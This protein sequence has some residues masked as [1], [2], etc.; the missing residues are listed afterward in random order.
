MLLDHIV[1]LVNDLEAASA[2]YGRLGFTVTPGGE[3]ADGNSHNALI[4]FS[5]GAYIELIAFKR[6]PPPEHL[7]ARGVARG[8]GM[9]T[10]AL[11]PDDIEADVAA[12]KARGLDLEGPYPGGRLRPDGVR[13]EWLTAR[14][15]TPDL[16][17]LCADVTPRELRVPGGDAMRH[18]NGVQA[19]AG[20][21][22]LVTNLVIST[23][24]Y[25]ALLHDEPIYTPHKIS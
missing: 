5:D 2:D 17:F 21:V 12:A 15:A 3:H 25:S 10:Y 20:V 13:L 8:E 7:F 18:E 23:R 14:A 4:P 24:R 9:I 1:I 19:I 11:L 16:P 22:V 6:P